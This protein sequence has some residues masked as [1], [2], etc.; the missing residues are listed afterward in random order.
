LQDGY[1]LDPIVNVIV[2]EFSRYSVLVFGAVN[3]PGRVEL[4]GPRHLLDVLMMA[5]GL[6]D[7]AGA[8]AVV[9][10]ANP[11]PELVFEQRARVK[12][13]G[14]VA[15]G[16]EV[17]TPG[18]ELI[19]LRRLIEEGNPQLNVPIFPEDRINIPHAGRVYLRGSCLKPGEYQLRGAN[20]TLTQVIA[21]AGGYLP[22]KSTST[23]EIQRRNPATK[24]LDTLVIDVRAVLDNDAPDIVLVDGDDVFF[25]TSWWRASISNTLAFLDRVLFGFGPRVI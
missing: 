16:S 2:L 14:S 17:R 24:E 3:N 11:N 7:T 10:R 9:Y 1:V 4:S 8:R 13:T 23:I 6:R 5:G 20:T 18:V 19:D 21:Q 22:F 15:T 12:V 25:P